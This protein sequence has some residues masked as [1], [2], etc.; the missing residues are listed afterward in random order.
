MLVLCYLAISW[1]YIRKF[2]KCK[3]FF[4]FAVYCM[5][6]IAKSTLRE[7]WEKHRDAEIPLKTWY[8][9]ATRADW[10]TTHDIKAM[11]GDA[12]F[13]ANNRVVFNIKGNKYRIVVYI[14]FKV[15]KVFIRFVGT[16]AQYDKID[17]FKI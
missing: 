13:V 5:R 16:H 12:S 3:L 4:I 8:V 2:T 7:F 11:F 1:K 17:A 10:Q 15:K 14:I 9:L 6:V